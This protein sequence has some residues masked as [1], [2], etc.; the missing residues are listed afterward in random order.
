MPADL[1]RTRWRSAHSPPRRRLQPRGEEARRRRAGGAARCAHSCATR[2]VDVGGEWVRAAGRMC[3]ALDVC[4]RCGVWCRRLSLAEC[5]AAVCAPSAA[6]SSSLRRLSSEPANKR[7]SPRRPRGENERHLTTLHYRLSNTANMQWS[8][9]MNVR[10]CNV[11]QRITIVRA[12][13]SRWM[14]VDRT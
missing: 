12:A 1:L 10:R 13:S 14:P 4:A 9:H 11:Q 7:E 3:A 5:A 2:I 6:A 8:K